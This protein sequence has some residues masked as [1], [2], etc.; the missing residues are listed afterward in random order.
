MLC[1]RRKKGESIKIGEETVVTVLDFRGDTVLIGI[2]APREQKVLR[3]ELVAD[4][5]VD[6]QDEAA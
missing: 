3:L 6:R 4:Q 5:H 2:D 1:L